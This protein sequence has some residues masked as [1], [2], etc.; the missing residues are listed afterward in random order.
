M[1]FDTIASIS[2]ALGGAIGIVRLSGDDSLK[3]LKKIFKPKY[4]KDV[5]FKSHRIYYGDIFDGENI[6]DEVLVSVMLAP[7]TYTV[8]DVVEINCH[9]GVRAVNM[10]LSA[11]I[12]NGA[13]MAEPGEFTKRAFLNGRIDLTKALAVIDIINAKT[14]LAHLGAV[15]R[16]SGMTHEKIVKLRADILTLLAGIEVSIDYPEHE[17]E[18]DNIL[19]I[20]KTVYYLRDELKKLIAGAE[21]GIVLKSGIEAVI[22]GRPNVGKS[23]LMN[24]ILREDRAIV[25]DIPGTTRDIL[26]EHININGIPIKITDT[27]GIRETDD[28]IEQ[29]GVNKAKDM[30]NLAQLLFVVL[31]GS[32]PISSYDKEILDLAKNKKTIIVINKCDLEQKIDISEFEGNHCVVRLSA[33]S[34]ENLDELYKAISDMFF[35]GDID[36]NNDIFISDVRNKN[37][38]VNAKE[39]LDNV[40][41]SIEMG[42]TEDLL[43][44]DLTESYVF[45]G[46]IIGES[47]SEDVIDKMFSEFC[48]GK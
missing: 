14:E 24:L 15:K 42:F 21:C 22:L 25:T 18:E 35:K 1:N 33:K 23:S 3:I 46:E 30:L 37:L 5:E 20:K 7:K 28:V 4:K 16:L 41:S 17:Y 38:L 48:L 11:V 9:G 45:L 10:V 26:T 36:I 6:I 39:R 27:A 29:A 44:V 8:E 2:T 47:V 43:S 31:D 13:R 40:L 12:K 32:M 19:L 34:G